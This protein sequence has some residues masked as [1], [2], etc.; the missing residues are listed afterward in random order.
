M[1]GATLVFKNGAL[2]YISSVRP[3]SSAIPVSQSRVSE[4]KTAA[5][6]PLILVAFSSSRASPGR[7]GTEW[8][9][10]GRRSP[11]SP[12]SSLRSHE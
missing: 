3:L 11:G 7:S 4:L 12:P 9:G 1:T 10:A 8:D 5:L 2:V 6:G